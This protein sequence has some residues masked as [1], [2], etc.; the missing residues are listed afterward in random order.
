MRAISLT[1]A[2]ALIEIAPLYLYP[3]LI[4]ILLDPPFCPFVYPIICHRARLQTDESARW[5]FRARYGAVGNYWIRMSSLLNRFGKR[6]SQIATKMARPNEKRREVEAL[7][8]MN[9]DHLIACQWLAMEV[10]QFHNIV[11]WLTHA[12]RLPYWLAD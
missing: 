6:S 4:N 3:A 7:F 12:S 11:P 1:R 5:L 10:V 8:R 9:S 2:D